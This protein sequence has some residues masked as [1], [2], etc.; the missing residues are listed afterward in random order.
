[1][2]HEFERTYAVVAALGVP[3][4][5]GGVVATYRTIAEALKH[6]LMR[7]GV[8]TIPVAPRRDGS[9]DTAA[10]CFERHGAW[11]LVAQGRK[12]VG[13]AQA[14]RRGAFLQHGSIP[15]RLDPSRM[16]TV[17]GSVVDGSRF[18]DLE[19]AR[20]R[21]VDP[22]ALDQACIDGFE[23]TFGVRLVRGTLT[24]AEELRAAELR[25]WKY[26]SMAW[27]C[28]GAIGSREARWGPSVSG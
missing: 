4:F 23:A 22:G 18:I 28:G 26:D 27:T 3:P 15:L 1:M 12:L 17:F 20:G 5:S 9:R 2:L 19:R 7:L 21:S 11:E 25:C 8:E 14:R 10:C 13:S 6:G 16:T 24:E